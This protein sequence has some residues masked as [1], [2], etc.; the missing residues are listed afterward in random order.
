MAVNGNF[1]LKGTREGFHLDQML[2]ERMLITG[3]RVGQRRHF[4]DMLELMALHK[5]LPVLDAGHFKL[6]ELPVVCRHLQT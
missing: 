4:E 5:A 3:I 6:T 2:M 1:G